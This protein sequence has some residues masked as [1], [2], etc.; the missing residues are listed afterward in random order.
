MLGRIRS[1]NDLISSD[2]LDDGFHLNE[3][4]EYEKQKRKT[5]ILKLRYEAH[6]TIIQSRWRGVITRS[7]S[8]R[9]VNPES[10]PNQKTLQKSFS[11]FSL[12]EKKSL[13]SK[14]SNAK[15]SLSQ[16]NM[17]DMLRKDPEKA[18]V[19]SG[20]TTKTFKRADTQI[21]NHQRNDMLTFT[22]ISSVIF[23]VDGAVG[24][25]HCCTATRVSARLL[26]GGRD[27]VIGADP[28]L[29]ANPECNVRSPRY[30]LQLKWEGE[31][32]F[33]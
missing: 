6:A 29:V 2:D 5:R 26:A 15:S 13:P 9:K 7:S 1:N 14:Y 16:F 8:A 21:S 24:L 30:T 19:D 12:T 3:T 33:F 23:I 32:Q 22:Q 10:R 18:S 11:D 27:S 31:S 20:P 28:P 4:T 25:P 17:D